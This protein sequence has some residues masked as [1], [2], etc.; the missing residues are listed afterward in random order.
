MALLDLNAAFDTADSSQNAAWGQITFI[1]KSASQPEL[2]HHQRNSGP[3]DILQLAIV[4]VMII[5]SIATIRVV[6][7][8]PQDSA[9]DQLQVLFLLHVAQNGQI[10]SVGGC[11]VGCQMFPD[12]FRVAL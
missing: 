4:K 7:R 9:A 6:F 5:S 11:R 10:E 12:V 2:A 1:I 3:E 8:V